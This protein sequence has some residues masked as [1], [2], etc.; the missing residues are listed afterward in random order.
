MHTSQDMCSCFYL[1]YMCA[2]MVIKTIIKVCAGLK[3]SIRHSHTRVLHGSSMSWLIKSFG[4]N[5]VSR[6][7]FNCH[8]RFY[9]TWGI[10][11]IFFYVPFSNYRFLK[12]LP[13]LG[14]K[15]TK[16]KNNW[17]TLCENTIACCHRLCKKGKN[18]RNM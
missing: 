5:L 6:W 8:K 16:Q 4:V 2:L 7:F 11:C 3:C 14:A 1:Q 13:F 12:N 17:S 9:G 18:F 15:P 10:H